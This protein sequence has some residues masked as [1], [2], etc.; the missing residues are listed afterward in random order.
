MLT[1]ALL[2]T[3]LL[4]G[5]GVAPDISANNAP[6]ANSVTRFTISAS[7]NLGSYPEIQ[8]DQ[9]QYEVAPGGAPIS[10]VLGGK[11]RDSWGSSYAYSSEFIQFFYTG[12]AKAAANVYLGLRIV[13]VCIWYSRNNAPVSSTVCSYANSD[14]GTWIGGPEVSVGATDSL[15]PNAPRTYFNIQTGR[16]NPNII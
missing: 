1:A 2:A 12:R 3:S 11:T 8:Y 6:I 4:T 15:D 7:P 9:Y 13:M 14:T 5:Q 10:L 16:L